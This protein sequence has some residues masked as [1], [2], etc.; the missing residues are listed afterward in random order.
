MK[1]IEILTFEK[2]SDRSF[3]ATGRIENRNFEAKTILHKGVPIFKIFED[4][5]L[6]TA[7]DSNFTVGEKMSVARLL[8]KYSLGKVD[9][10]GRPSDDQKNTGVGLVIQ[11]QN[12]ID[13]LNS[14]I[15]RLKLIL[16]DNN[17]EFQEEEEEEE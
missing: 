2:I 3:R 17:I 13:D 10:L 14:E 5:I 11:L 16:E 7:K 4:G 9:K 15:H 6:K 8:K 12:Q 1:D